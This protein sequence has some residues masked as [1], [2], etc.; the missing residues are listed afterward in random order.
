MIHSIVNVIKMSSSTFKSKWHKSISIGQ[1]YCRRTVLSVIH[2]VGE[3]SCRRTILSVNCPVGELSGRQKVCRRTVRWRTVCW[4]TVRVPSKHYSNWL[5]KGFTKSGLTQLNNDAF[6]RPISQEHKKTWTW[7][8]I[9]V[10]GSCLKNLTG[11]HIS[12][13][14][15][16]FCYFFFM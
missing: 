2:P 10:N 3:L 15:T 12:K 8:F 16:Y 4:R 13:K 14:K 7:I 1:L 9:T 11:R 5:V 6:R